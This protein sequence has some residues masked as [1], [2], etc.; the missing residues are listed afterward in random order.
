MCVC[1]WGSSFIIDLCSATP[2]QLATLSVQLTLTYSVQLNCVNVFISCIII[3]L[4]VIFI[5]HPQLLRGVIKV[6]VSFVCFC[7]YTKLC[8][9]LL[10]VLIIYDDWLH[11]RNAESMPED[12]YTHA[13]LRELNCIVPLKITSSVKLTLRCMQACSTTTYSA[14][15]PSEKHSA[16]Q[17][18]NGQWGQLRWTLLETD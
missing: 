17:Y 8:N 5:L 10:A 16:Q 13:A 11:F 4:F 6:L 2:G 7:F 15:R 12:K 3:C 18:Q 14:A 9:L 1:V